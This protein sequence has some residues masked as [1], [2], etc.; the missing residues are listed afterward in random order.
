M[1]LDAPLVHL[2]Q[3]LLVCPDNVFDTLINGPEFSIGDDDGNLYDN[4]LVMVQTY[5]AWETSGKCL[6]FRLSLTSD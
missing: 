1:R 6:S 4:V 5:I 2:I 3:R